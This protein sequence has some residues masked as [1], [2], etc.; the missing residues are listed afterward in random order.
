MI[1]SSMNSTLKAILEL[2]N[3]FVQMPAGGGKSLI[4]Q[5]I[6]GVSSGPVVCMSPLK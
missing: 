2:D 6:V 4:Y 3:V 5:I 1:F